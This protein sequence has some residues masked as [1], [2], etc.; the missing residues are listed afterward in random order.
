MTT[1]ANLTRTIEESKP[2]VALTAALKMRVDRAVDGKQRILLRH[3]SE[4]SRPYSRPP[5][6]ISIISR[7]LRN[8][9]SV[10]FFTRGIVLLALGDTL[11]VE[12]LDD[13]GHGAKIPAGNGAGQSQSA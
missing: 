2:R 1:A 10:N 6:S 12:V 5:I 4:A 9:P 11:G 8:E 13:M 3:I 7:A